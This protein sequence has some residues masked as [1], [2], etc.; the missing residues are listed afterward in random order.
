MGLCSA[1]ESAHMVGLLT[2]HTELHAQ[3]PV[4]CIRKFFDSPAELWEKGVSGVLNF[5]MRG[6]KAAIWS[7]VVFE[8]LKVFDYLTGLVLIVSIVISEN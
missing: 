3:V 4:L 1:S 8:F 7:Y 5:R 6:V 2:Q